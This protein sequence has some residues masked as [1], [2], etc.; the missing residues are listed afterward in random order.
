MHAF[1]RTTTLILALAGIARGQDPIIVHPAGPVAFTVPSPYTVEQGPGYITVRWG[2]PIPTPT[3]VPRPTPTPIP[4]P[5][6]EPPPATISG[7]V[8]VSLVLSVES[9]PDQAAM[10][11]ELLRTNWRQQGDGFRAYTD[12][13]ADL[14]ALNLAGRYSAGDL[15]V[16]FIQ[17][18]PSRGTEWPVA[19]VLKRATT[20]D[21]AKALKELR[22]R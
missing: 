1:A 18:V 2:A 14:V 8:F 12:G 7:P 22:G 13:Q 9:T 15:P 10:R 21:L 19:R 3:P 17:V 5:E 16:I 11:D 6:P 4:T 20:K